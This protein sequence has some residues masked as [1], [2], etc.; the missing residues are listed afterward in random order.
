MIN[1]AI[2]ARSVSA[3][4]V[5]GSLPRGILHH[6]DIQNYS[7]T[8]PVT[9]EFSQ[10]CLVVGAF[11]RRMR[12]Q[13][14]DQRKISAR[15]KGKTLRPVCGDHVTAGPIRNEPEWL[16]S[17]ICPRKNELARPNSRGRKEVLAAN[18]DCIV[19]MAAAAPRPDWFVVDRYLAAAE[20]M[21]A[22][23]IVVLNKTDLLDMSTPIETCLHEYSSIGHRVMKCSARTGAN[24]GELTAALK[25]KTAIIVG[26]SGVGKSSVIN[27]IVIDAELRT[28]SLSGSSGEGRHTTVTSV[29]LNLT[30]G[31][32]VIDSPGVRDYAPTVENI[33]DINR[34]FREVSEL[35]QYCRFADCRHLRE[36]DC[37]VKSAVDDETMSARRYESYK[38]LMSSSKKLAD[39]FG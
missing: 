24:L 16:I 29:L 19:V 18:L 39:K 8:A 2:L 6:H 3:S 36:P 15:I 27:Q 32:A 22:E 7:S 14:E 31:G 13:L 20:I 34:G 4:G 11:S 9:D 26:Q 30:N 21:D 35:S 17:G 25:G 1:P 38:R 23:G 10:K 33:P 5:Q 28:G 12:L 37:A